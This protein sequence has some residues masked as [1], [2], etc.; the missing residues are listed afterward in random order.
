MKVP[1]PV[2]TLSQSGKA[3]PGKS[4]IIKEYMI[5]SRPDMLSGEAVTAAR[6]IQDTMLKTICSKSGIG[7]KSL[8]ESGALCPTYDKPEQGLDAIAEAAGQAGY[9]M[10]KDFFFILNSSAQDCF[11]YE[12]GKYEVVSGMLKGPDD[13]ADYWLDL[14]SRYESIVGIIDP[15]RCEEQEQWNKICAAISDHCLIIS[16]KGYSRPGILREEEPD[17]TKFATSGLIMKLEGSNTTAHIA[18]CA[19]KMTDLNNVV[20]MAAGLRESNDTT[21]V[22]IAT[23]CQAHFLKMGPVCRGERIAKYNRL[24]DIENE[25]GERRAE[26][27]SLAF[28]SIPPKVPTPTPELEENGEAETANDNN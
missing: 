27:D 20:I 4:N 2:I 8:H 26:W 25:L 15:L 7:I 18:E 17:F 5:V 28:P 6:K 3:S 16:E 1:Q 23:A 22:D 10:G 21:I 14:C 9:E 12:K 19:K 13:M 24:I 11:D